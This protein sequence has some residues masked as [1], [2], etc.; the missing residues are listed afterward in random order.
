[1]RQQSNG[2]MSKAAIGLM[3]VFFIGA[4]AFVMAPE[5]VCAET[6]TAGSWQEL[7]NEL[8]TLDNTTIQL[9]EYCTA[10]EDDTCLILPEGRNITLDLNGKMINR[11]RSNGD[12]SNLENGVVMKV[13]GTLEITD[14]QGGGVITGG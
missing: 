1:M 10:A 4:L 13:Y 5:E 9:S 8:G 11:N 6:A 14:S 12:W 3:V 7:Q 2:R